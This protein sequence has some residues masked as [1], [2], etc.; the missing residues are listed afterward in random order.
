MRKNLNV[1]IRTDGSRELGNGHIIRMLALADE[2]FFRGI[3]FIFALK[4]DDYWIKKI[5]E[6]KFGVVQLSEGSNHLEVFRDI[7]IEKKITHL[8]YDTRGDLTKD[9]LSY[10]RETASLQVIVIDSPEDTRL[11]AD[12]AVFPPVPQIKMWSWSG[13]KGRIFSGWEYV[14]LRK[15]FLRKNAALELIDTKRILLSFGSTDPFC[16][17]E[18]ILKLI[19]GNKK[20]FSNYEFIL[21]VGPQFDR[22]DAIIESA[23]FKHL[24]ISIQKSPGDIASL[25]RSV[26]IAIIAFG[27]TAYELTALSIPFLCISLTED[28]E[29]SSR[30]FE[31][32]GL[33]VSLGLLNNFAEGFK[34]K[35]E[36]YFDHYELMKKHIKDFQSKKLICDWPRIIDAITN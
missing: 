36:Y 13:F 21:L 18:K 16:M 9:G 29:R 20:I 3:Q 1:L 7:L 11:A 25:F 24:K 33:C 28:H 27:V 26:D 2:L 12:V 23:D 17:T 34:A 4:F 5:L 22:L 15:E 31:E 14:L 30:V 6:K 19:A 35:M 32:N 10:L 8:V